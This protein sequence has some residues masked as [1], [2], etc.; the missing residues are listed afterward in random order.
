MLLKSPKTGFADEPSF[1]ASP[2][3]VRA[4]IPLSLTNCKA[5]DIISSLVNLNLGG[6]FLYPFVIRNSSY[7]TLVFYYKLFFVFVKRVAMDIFSDDQEVLNAGTAYV[8]ARNID[9]YINHWC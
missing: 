1:D 5:D 4:E 8:Y 3:A 2:L 6:I 7:A 9:R